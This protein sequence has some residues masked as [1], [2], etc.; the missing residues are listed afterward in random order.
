MAPVARRS[1]GRLWRPCKTIRIQK[2][3]STFSCTQHQPCH[4]SKSSRK[5]SKTDSD[6]ILI[7]REFLSFSWMRSYQPPLTD[8]TT[9]HWRYCG[10]QLR[11][12]VWR[13]TL[14]CACRAIFWWTRLVLHSRTHSSSYFA[15]PAHRYTATRTTQLCKRASSK[16]RCQSSSNYTIASSSGPTASAALSLTSLHAIPRGHLTTLKAFGAWNKRNWERCKS[17]YHIL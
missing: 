2:W 6:S 8:R 4:T 7:Q 1:S 11:S 12:F 5:R 10:S 9:R 14:S 16:S 15:V 3:T 13:C 17:N